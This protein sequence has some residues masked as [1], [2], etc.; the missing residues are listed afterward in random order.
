MFKFKETFDRLMAAITFA[1]ANDHETALDI[2]H[3]RPERES[4]KSVDVQIRRNEETRPQ[5][6]I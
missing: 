6:R 1:Q 3:D 2:M 5:M 4:R